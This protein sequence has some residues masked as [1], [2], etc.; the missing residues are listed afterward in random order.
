MSTLSGNGSII[1]IPYKVPH[2]CEKYKG[3]TQVYN[4]PVLSG[5]GTPGG[6]MTVSEY[7]EARQATIID[8]QLQGA[9]EGHRGDGYWQLGNFGTD[10]ASASVA[11]DDLRAFINNKFVENFAKKYIIWESVVFSEEPY[12]FVSL[13]ENSHTGS[14]NYDSSLEFGDVATRASTSPTPTDEKEIIVGKIVS[15][16]GVIT[17]DKNVPNRRKWEDLQAHIFADSPHGGLWRQDTITTSGMT[18]WGTSENTIKLTSVVSGEYGDVPGAPGDFTF[19][20]HGDWEIKSGLEV[21]GTFLARD[22]VAQYNTTKQLSQSYIQNLTVDSGLKVYCETN[23]YT[24][25][26]F[27]DKNYISGFG[28]APINKRDWPELT[29]V[30]IRLPYYDPSMQGAILDA[31]LATE[32]K[33]PHHDVASGLH[34]VGVLSIYGDTLQSGLA[35]NSGISVDGIDLSDIKRMITGTVI[36]ST[37]H[38]HFLLSPIEFRYNFAPYE[39]CIM[40]GLNPGY[41]SENL[42]YNS[43]KTHT[44]WSSFSG[45][46]QMKITIREEVPMGVRELSGV[47]IFTRISSGFGNQSNVG[48]SLFD[49][50]ESL[51]SHSR[52]RSPYAFHSQTLSGNGVFQ[53]GDYY[54]VEL[55]LNSEQGVEVS[56][57]DIITRWVT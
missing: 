22:T 19:Q 55:E 52:A 21:R 2:I 9:I 14:Y 27:N 45:I 23:V 53:Q 26:E 48:M 31:H 10:V 7:C 20:G 36:T 43:G 46:Q 47:E 40:S 42:D 16:N 35:V 32:V 24:N 1:N 54:K 15:G 3:I 33:N 17:V 51:I 50:A 29:S 34:S 11:L 5:I 28:F 8:N 25:L 39:N 30:N 49:C 44:A 4:I 37:D 18:V 13:I 38:S 57:S 56:V 6:P 12:L 41:L